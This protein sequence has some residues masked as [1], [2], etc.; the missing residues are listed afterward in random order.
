MIGAMPFGGQRESAPPRIPPHNYE[1]EQA[2]IGALLANNN[3]YAMVAGMVH[4]DDFADALHGRIYT[5]ICRLIERGEIANFLTLRDHFERDPALADAGGAKYLARLENSVVTIINAD[6]YARTIRD[7][8]DRR[9]LIIVCE[10]AIE[11]AHLVDIDKP[12]TH[13]MASL[14]SELQGS[15][16]GADDGLTTVA[17]VAERIVSG[18]NEELPCFPT[19]LT[20][21]D[22]VIAGGLCSQK[23][24]GIAA[25][26]KAGK[27]LLMAT[28]AYNLTLADV[29]TPYLSLEMGPD[30]Q[31]QRLMAR[32]M[33]LN[34]LSFLDRRARRSQGFQRD[35][36]EAALKL[37]R[38][39]HL[40]L[41]QRP[42]M[43]LEDV[44]QTIARAAL[45]RRVKGVFVDYLQLIGGQRHNET[46]AAH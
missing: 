21:L 30:E 43:A 17:D 34:S 1:A 38:H 15:V 18:L 40:V 27:R 11:A 3:V 41:M 22:E 33:G 31:V 25:D 20:R 5:A 12:A 16:S 10:E 37:R 6:D 29:P 8:A 32:M 23:F 9:R 28:I 2:L 42:R 39:N 45:S 26:R 35:A 7:L 19:G 4:A 46:L 44:R 14:V 13:V 24:Y 36:A